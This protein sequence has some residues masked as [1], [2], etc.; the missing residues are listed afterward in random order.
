MNDSEYQTI[1]RHLESEFGY[2]TVKLRK[3]PKE[4]NESYLWFK[5]AEVSDGIFDRAMDVLRDFLDISLIYQD[6]GLGDY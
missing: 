1:N 4:E 2:Q 5:D 3:N 6:T